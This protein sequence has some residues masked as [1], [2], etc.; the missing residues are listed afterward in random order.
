MTKEGEF[1]IFCIEQ[2]KIS[3]HL[4]GKE[5]INLFCKYNV[6]DYILQCYEALHTTGVA[7]II[8]DIDEYIENQKKVA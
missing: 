5:V 6:I 2:Y 4:C 3:K 7:Y 8:N 1:L